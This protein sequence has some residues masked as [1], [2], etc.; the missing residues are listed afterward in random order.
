MRSR[1]SARSTR[2]SVSSAADPT[3]ARSCSAVRGRRSASSSS[4][5]RSASGVRSSWLASATKW[6]SRS[7]AAS[8]RASISL[9][10]SARSRISSRLGG[11]GSRAPGVVA[12]IALA[13]RRIDSTGRSAAAA[14]RYP[15]SVARS[16]PIGP[17][18]RSPPK[19]RWSV[20]SVCRSGRAR[21]STRSPSGTASTRQRFKSP[22]PSETV[23]RRVAATCGGDG[24]RVEESRQRRGVGAHDV[25]VGA[26]DL[27]DRARLAGVGV[28]ERAVLPVPDRLA[29]TAP[30]GPGR[31]SS[32][33]RPRPG[34]TRSAPS[35]RSSAAMRDREGGGEAP[36]DG[37]PLQHAAGSRSR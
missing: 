4:V 36:A 25:P 37:D 20:S 15:P 18:T 7:S 30:G 22:S 14:R 11:T 13:R 9:S 28:E 2:R 35:A 6:R 3:A 17:A 29:P 27:R 34:G 33:A 1:S 32:G 12:E 24:S 21:T 23:V 10:V 31:P 19:R 5:F 16:S 8:S 26:D